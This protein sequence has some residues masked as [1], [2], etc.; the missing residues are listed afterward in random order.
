[1]PD[2]NFLLETRLSED[3]Q[4]TLRLLER[5]C[6]EAGLNLYLTGGAMR[7]LVAAQPVRS[8]EITTE[9]DPVP[10][11]A[12][13]RQA[14]VEQLS[15]L[16]EQ[17]GLRFR[18][19]GVRVRLGA[20]QTAQGPAAIVEDLRHRGLTLNSIGLSL[21][22]GSRG[23]PLDPTN[24]IGDIEARLI[25]MSDAYVFY[26]HPITLLRAV[27]L[28]VRLEF[29]IEERTAARM[30]AAREGN[31]LERASGSDRGQEL[32]AILYQPMAAAIL[33]ALDAD[34]WLEPAF[35]KGVRT[36]KMQM[37]V[38]ARLPEAMAG[39][40]GLGLNVDAGLSA[41]PFVLGGLAP[42]DQN[43][44]TRWLPSQHLSVWKK[45]GGEAK[46]FEARWLKV[47]GNDWL[48]RGEEL[49]EA[50]APEVLVY[51]SVNP[52]NA[53]AGKKL[54]DFQTAAQ[55]ARARIPMA[56]LRSLGLAPGSQRGEA[57]IRPLYRR[58]LAG[59]AITDTELAQALR[60]AAAPPP[61]APPPAA[62]APKPARRAPRAPAPKPAPTHGGG[63]ERR[64]A[65]RASPAGGRS[66]ASERPAGTTP[67]K[68][69]RALK[70]TKA[71]PAVRR[72]S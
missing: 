27:R 4:L 58:L 12:A 10:L 44:L 11:S 24:G 18:S 20:A 61:A 49:I 2:Y 6:R 65:E 51:V 62:P 22:P 48:R 36:A 7:D 42:A 46:A 66:Q 57:L 17:R 39:W 25:R 45:L 37:G 54:R 68:G 16:A 71:A 38:L 56:V 5:L 34:Q 52:Q 32:E 41:L 47:S 19:R 15:V 8:L 14:G 69:G 26:D 29:G 30:V 53:K 59:E 43:R 55:Q 72:R 60:A 50:T 70:T 40:S 33:K 9:G 35:G 23:L 64:R 21:N 63:A 3:Q 67:A 31:Y 13:L 1:M 28:Q